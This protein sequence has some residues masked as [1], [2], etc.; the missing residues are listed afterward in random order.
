MATFARSI[1]VPRPPSSISMSINILAMLIGRARAGC[2]PAARPLAF[3]SFLISPLKERH[4]SSLAL[5]EFHPLTPFEMSDQCALDAKG[6]PLPAEDIIFYNSESD[7]TP[8]PS[9]KGM[10]IFFTNISSAHFCSR[11]ASQHSKE[12]NRQAHSLPCCR[13]RGRRRQFASCQSTRAS[14]PQARS[15]VQHGHLVG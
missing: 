5:S 10:F 4:K 1:T 12:G 2:I 13:K 7:E 9:S 15:P 8:L 14:C 11:T 6:N 3:F